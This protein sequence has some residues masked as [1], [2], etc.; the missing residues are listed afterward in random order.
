MALIKCSEC[1]GEI[2]DKALSCPHCGNP[3]CTEQNSGIVQTDDTTL[4]RE[5]D[6]IKKQ[7][8]PSITRV[9]IRICAL[10]IC[11]FI[12]LV[13]ASFLLIQV[14][15]SNTLTHKFIQPTQELQN[16]I[17]EN[18]SKT[19][20]MDKSELISKAITSKAVPNNINSLAVQNNPDGSKLYPVQ[21]INLWGYEFYTSK[22]DKSGD[23]DIGSEA[24]QNIAKLLKK[25]T[26]PPTL[27]K[28]LIIVHV[29]PTLVYQGDR[30]Q[31]PWVKE[32][33][34]ISLQPEGGTHQEVYGGSVIAL[35]NLVSNDSA[36]NQA[37]NSDA[38][39][40]MFLQGVLL[41]EQQGV[42]VH[43]LGHLIG[44]Q[45]TDVEWK[46]Y[47]K[48]RGIPSGTARRSSN[49]NMSPFEDFAEAYK[50]TY[51][52]GDV[53]TLFGTLI[54]TGTGD[55]TTP[56]MEISVNLQNEWR[57]KHPIKDNEEYL[58]YSPSKM[59]EAKAA[60]HS[61]PTLQ[62]CRRKNIKGQFGTNY[63]SEVN[64]TT[65]KYIESIVTRLNTS[66]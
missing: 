60:I 39:D 7:L 36:A 47:Y 2:S 58:I 37:Q 64:E 45:L 14:L 32:K 11:L 17:S 26:I 63:V 20:E 38:L 16:R 48:L 5:Q 50:N 29:D 8:L 59:D 66:K 13:P 53:R 25:L 10:S 24:K 1:S 65:K 56:C 15:P 35:N 46:R 33:I 31:I 3:I 18:I 49:W 6:I 55:M 62:A 34:S 40:Q 28:K 9:I 54:E 23:I 43:E 44:S 4:A 42:L 52:Y 22:I 51:G 61:D 21:Y 12:L 27:T 30:I 19:I 41:A 57:T